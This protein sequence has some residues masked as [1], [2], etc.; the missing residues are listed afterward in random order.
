MSTPEPTPTPDLIR[1]S[2]EATREQAAKQVESWMAATKD[3]AIRSLIQRIA[4]D[5]RNGPPQDEQTR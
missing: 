3:R 5:V 2:V 1:Q 4:N